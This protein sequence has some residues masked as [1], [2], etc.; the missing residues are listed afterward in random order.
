MQ[1]L[2]LFALLEE[3]FL[4]L[5]SRCDQ[6]LLLQQSLLLFQE[7]LLSS[8]CLK[9]GLGLLKLH[10]GVIGLVLLDDCLLLSPRPGVIN[11]DWFLLLGHY[12]YGGVDVDGGG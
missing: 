2:L 7:L 11:H 10:L 4:I 5:D 1:V 12:C 9:L 8:K 6:L 3:R